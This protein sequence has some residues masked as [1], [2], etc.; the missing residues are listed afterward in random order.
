MG[1]TLKQL[2]TRSAPGSF[3]AG[4]RCISSAK[5]ISGAGP[6]SLDLSVEGA[7]VRACE[8]LAVCERINLQNSV[9]SEASVSL[10]AMGMMYSPCECTAVLTAT[11][12]HKPY[13]AAP[14]FGNIASMPMRVQ[15]SGGKRLNLPKA[16][17][18]GAVFWHGGRRGNRVCGGPDSC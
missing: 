4:L 15:P 11:S 14:F 3:G 9:A 7:A 8:L 17:G 13:G 6:W 16:R 2:R 12:V 18:A 10:S 5:L 1:P